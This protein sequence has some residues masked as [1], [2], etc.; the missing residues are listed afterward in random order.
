MLLIYLY[1]FIL[2]AILGSFYNVVGLRVPLNQSIIKPRSHCPSCKRTLTA[3]DLVPI[4]SYLILGGKCRGCGQKISIKYPLIELSTAFLFV[5]A[6]YKIGFN[7]ELLTAWTFI[8]LLIIII[9]SDIA[10]MLIP[11]KILLFFLPLLIIERIWLPLNPWWDS[12]VG[13]F[14]G[15][16]LLF[17]IAVISKGGMGG[18]DI[19]LYFLIGIVL[20]FKFTLLSFFIATFIGAIYGLGIIM[21]GKFK[22]RQPIPFGPFIVVGSLMAYFY[23]ER[24]INWYINTFYLF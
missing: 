1:I 22:K 18:G 16:G 11:D 21:V 10:Y 14:F 20:G 13:A 4:F 19:K 2:G 24:I 3:V 12:I 7:W 17:F 23:G 6:F 5:L 8:S 9:V 15:F